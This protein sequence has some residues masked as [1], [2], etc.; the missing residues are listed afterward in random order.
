[1]STSTATSKK[2]PPPTS[3]EDARY[4]RYIAQRLDKTRVQVKLIDLIGALMVLAAAVLGVLLVLAIIDHWVVPLGGIGRWL[5]LLVLLVGV[6]FYF[7]VVLVPLVFG[8]INP[9]YAARAIEKG[10]PSL[11][12]SLINFLMFRSDRAGVR[13]A[14]YQ[15]L[16]RQAATDLSHVQVETAV[17]RSK[18]IKIGYVLA[19]VLTICALYT[20]LSPKSTFQSAARV[21]APWAD[22]ARPSRVRIENVLPGDKEVFYGET[23]SVSADCYDVREDEPVTLFFSTLDSRVSS[24]SIVMRPGEGGLKYRCVVPADDEGIQQDLVYWIEAGDART[25]P[26]RLTVLPAPTILVERVEYEYAAYTN[27]SR[28]AIERQGDLKGPEGT[29]VTVR[30][31]ANQPIVSAVIEFDPDAMAL[32]P[33]DTNGRTE[34][35][36]SRPDTLEME[37]DG[38]RARC[39]FVLE[40]DAS[41]TSPKHSFYQIRFTT[42]E[43]ARN[44]HPILHRIEVTRDLSPEIEILT[45]TRDKIEIREDGQQTIE[46]R[47][48]DPDYGL[49]RIALRAVAG[50]HDLLEQALLS[51]PAGQSGQVVVTYDFKPLEHGL[52]AGDAAAYWAVAEDN[53]TSPTTAAPAP[54]VARTRTYHIT[55]LPPEKQP[56]AEEQTPETE[57]MPPDASSQPSTPEEPGSPDS[58]LSDDGQPDAQEGEGQEGDVNDGQSGGEGNQAG[59]ESSGSESDGGSPSGDDSQG[60]SGGQSGESE[61]GNGGTGQ[62]TQPSTNGSDSGSTSDTPGKGGGSAGEPTGNS[63]AGESSDGA[64][65]DSAAGGGTGGES[66]SGSSGSASGQPGQGSGREEPLHDGE[67]FETAMEHMKQGQEGTP[68]GQNTTEQGD[69]QPQP[70]EASSDSQPQD[71]AESTGQPGDA[72]SSS[73]SQETPEGAGQQGSA[74]QGTSGGASEGNQQQNASDKQDGTGSESSSSGQQ[75]QGADGQQEGGGKQPEEKQGAGQQKDGSSGQ[76]GKPRSGAQPKQQEKSGSS[77]AGKPK[78]SGQGDNGKSGGGQNSKDQSGAAGSQ[79]KSQDRHKQ[80]G[81]SGG[82]PKPGSQSQSPGQSKRQSDSSGS[83]G[84]DRSGGGKKGGGQG[85]KQPGNDSAGSSSSGDDGQGSSS[86]SGAGDESSR[87]GDKA[88][89]QGDTGTPGMQKGHG[90]ETDST[91]GGKSEGGATGDRPQGER[92]AESSGSPTPGAVDTRGQG[93]PLGGGMPSAADLRGF[94]MTGQVPPG[95]KPNMEYAR[96]ATDLVLEFL[97]DQQQNPDQELL[98]KLGWTKEEMQDFTARWDALKR[99]SVEEN[100]GSRELDEALRSLG[101]RPRRGTTRHVESRDDESRGLRDAGTHSNPPP[102]YAEQFNAY[103]K[104][105]SRTGSD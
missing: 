61:S 52:H 77:S 2:V 60:T 57:Q 95:E 11:K 72:S 83:Q 1:M 12:N 6:G 29:R 63:E 45:P 39:S 8:R 3:P 24:E 96:K 80:G 99:A 41:R 82:Q 101:L 94:D 85:A 38:D 49:S 79:K 93:L 70:S 55:I 65:S 5:A 40:L 54:N 84:G 75:K 22:V 28:K 27:R 7:A 16:E 30:A 76:S 97:K 20:I 47:A 31:R 34:T 62:G 33:R 13:A 43:G 71:G 58:S 64:T 48:V 56:A 21:I 37:F 25:E 103:K 78:D 15:G 44:P 100:K 67:V 50:G 69:G 51:E 35:S 18:V 42:E 66:Q 19:G 87:P 53:R 86:E 17:D 74:K 73:P 89:S 92:T 26:H 105:T 98:E 68:T 10:E 91:P 59:S 14:V 90:S 9:A 88:P 4:D 102:G 36:M 23:V 32:E 81:S 104:G 46:I